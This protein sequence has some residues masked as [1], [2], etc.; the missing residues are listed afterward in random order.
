MEKISTWLIV[1]EMQ[2]KLAKY[3]FHLANQQSNLETNAT[4]S[5]LQ[6]NHYSPV[7]PKV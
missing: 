6:S 5:R 1:K 4:P 7:R 3:C 2:A